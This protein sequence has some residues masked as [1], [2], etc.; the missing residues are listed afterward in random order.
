MDAFDDSR[1]Q[2]RTA[3]VAI[4][5]MLPIAVIG[6]MLIEGMPLLDA[7]WLTVITLATIGYGDTFARTP[8]GRAFT[9]LLVFF[10]LG[11]FA[12][13]LQAAAAF[14]VSPG[15]RAI[16]MRRQALSKIKAL[17]GH[18]ILCGSGELV[19]NIIAF[20]I[21]RAA[22]RRE[23]NL[24]LSV[25]RIEERIA[26]LFGRQAWSAPLRHPIQRIVLFFWQL[27]HRPTTLIDLM[28]IVTKEPAYANHLRE[29]G[30]L[31]V[32]ADPTDEA[33]ILDAGI[34]H[35]AA[36][37]VVLESDTE[38]LMTVLT[39]RSKNNDVYITAAIQDEEIRLK[40]VRVGANNVLAPFEAAGQFLTNATL[41]PVVNDFFNDILY[42]QSG[43]FMLQM[44]LAED[45]PWIG[46]TLA[47]LAL[48]TRFGASVIALR[49]E[50]GSF[51]Y[52][53]HEDYV[54]NENEILLV[55]SPVETL[56]LL[57]NDAQRAEVWT[58]G[59]LNWQ[60]LPP[61]PYQPAINKQH[62]LLECEGLVSQM[63]QHY[64]ICGDGRVIRNIVSKLNP[65][66]PFVILSD[67]PQIVADMLKRGFRVI[68][69]DPTHDV[70]LRKAGVTRA[71]A[72]MVSIDNDADNV[73]TVLNARTLSRQLL[74]TATANH[75][76]MISKLQRA[77]A[78]RVVSPFRVA[79]QFVLLATTRPA[80]HDFMQYVLYNRQTGLETTELYMMHDS[81]W[82]GRLIGD[83][84]LR[85]QYRA[86]IVGIRQTNGRFLYAPPEDYVIQMDEVLV[87]V[88]PIDLS[89]QLRAAGHGGMDRRPRSLRL[90][91][92]PRVG[93]WA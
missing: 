84:Q 82:I 62:S 5:I 54:L 12:Y 4:G 19:D 78:D 40:I 31:V 76:A 91:E 23:T 83:L 93:I 35:A 86:G 2:L 70:T 15:M 56:A 59:A 85:Q 26:Q 34:E 57:Q 41:R 81:P 65:E 25:V 49:C 61:S 30:L 58:Q 51:I 77:G 69:G 92:L 71:L 20:L 43:G 87:I 13:A 52:V 90:D 79:A 63:S 48:R 80:V 1:R 9:I 10:G 42:E 21:Q 89:D 24:Q 75:D 66:R 17:R 27:T 88:T 68:H 33:S 7:I 73:M 36:L 18:Y 38:A 67:H 39:A 37:M 3:L 11:T 6:F 45:S 50:D 8:E 60:R 44:F 55:I 16:R 28:V 64:I 74:I 72:L 53:P 22:L 47:A 29:Q 46:Q 14:F 32:E